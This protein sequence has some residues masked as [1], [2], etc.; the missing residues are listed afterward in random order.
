V[1]IR[2]HAE[3]PA[4]LLIEGGGPT[5]IRVAPAQHA[6]G[7][8]SE[9]LVTEAFARDHGLVIATTELAYR[10]P[11]PLTE[12]QRDQVEDLMLDSD[13]PVA[14]DGGPVRFLDL[15]WYQP[16]SGPSPFQLELL[17]TGIAL[18]FSVFIVGASL[19]LAAAESKDERDVLTVAGAP[20]GALARAAG[21]R[22]W[23]LSGL[24]GL[25]AVPIGFLP[26]V[27]FVQADDGDFPL[28]FP[29]TTVALLLVAVPT[30]VGLVAMASSATAQRL[31]PV[32][33]ST[34]TFE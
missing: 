21:A 34:A 17:L 3:D 26:M 32:R 11:E 9:V 28:V 31:R 1:L 2:R 19:A 20:P 22:A 27:V 8:G 30:V 16:E 5:A 4:Q 18:A 12:D 24:G 14:G 6:A 7:R 25:L 29:S 33:V 10:S 23:L 15:T 13:P